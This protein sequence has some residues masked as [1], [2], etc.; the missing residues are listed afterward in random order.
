MDHP[1]HS[2]GFGKSLL[3]SMDWEHTLT[4]LNI[5]QPKANEDTQDRPR[6]TPASSFVHDDFL[7]PSKGHGIDR[8]VVDQVTAASLQQIQRA[9]RGMVLLTGDLVVAKAWWSL[10]W[11]REDVGRGKVWQCGNSAT[12][13]ACMDFSDPASMRSWRPWQELAGG[14]YEIYIISSRVKPLGPLGPDAPERS[15]TPLAW[16]LDELGARTKHRHP[17]SLPESPTS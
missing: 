8:H 17:K 4:I 2:F 7:H 16:L 14:V 10:E 3:I 12:P 6:R 15:A 9:T 5:L 1:G 13:T 11:W